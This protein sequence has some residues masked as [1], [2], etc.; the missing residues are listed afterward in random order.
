MSHKG[1]KK[2]T[3]SAIRNKET[4]AQDSQDLGHHL[5]KVNK[6]GLPKKNI[7][8]PTPAYRIKTRGKFIVL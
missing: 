2:R 8:A 6:S 1:V 3:S 5:K 4:Q 7:L